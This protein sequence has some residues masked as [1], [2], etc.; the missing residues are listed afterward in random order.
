MLNDDITYQDENAATTHLSAGKHNLTTKQ[1]AA[2][3]RHTQWSQD[4]LYADIL[5]Q[6]T[7]AFINHYMVPDCSLSRYFKL[8][9]ENAST[10][11]RIEHFNNFQRGLEHLASS[12]AGSL[13]TVIH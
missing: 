1:I 12:N 2:I 7:A 10:N 11:I 5:A 13:A 9:S 6:L 8:L 3:L 4:D